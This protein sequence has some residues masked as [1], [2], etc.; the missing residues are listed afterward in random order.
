MSDKV[1]DVLGTTEAGMQKA[2]ENLRRELATVRTGRASP[3]LLDR[4]L[5][6]YYGV[7][8][9]ISAIANIS[10]PEPRLLIIAPW[11][12]NM[13]G[14]IEK[15]IHKSDLGITPSSD[16]KVIRLAIPQLTEERRREMTKTVKKRT[17]EGKV[18]LRNT[19]R[20][21]VEDL[22]KAEK[23]KEISEDDLKRGQERLQKLT[24]SY[25]GKAEEVGQ[26]KER[27]IMEF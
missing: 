23:D 19:R 16:G 6:D 8:T 21:G 24:D 12:K 13:I 18:A 27:E 22:K 15:A 17:E 5:V 1:N 4:I 25:I 14:A 11:E 3:S 26:Q 10:T 7:P 2:I 9:Q 20:D